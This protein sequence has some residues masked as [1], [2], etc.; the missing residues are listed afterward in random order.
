MKHQKP[1]PPATVDANVQKPNLHMWTTYNINTEVTVHTMNFLQV[2]LDVYCLLGHHTTA[3]PLVV[4]GFCSPHICPVGL[5]GALTSAYVAPAIT[6][7]VM[8]R[9]DVGTDP[10]PVHLLLVGY[11]PLWCSNA[12]S[13]A[14][15][16]CSIAVF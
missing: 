4:V 3:V 7:G 12:L 15:F 9:L 2:P 1:N 5:V 11:S 13:I 10:L 8:V 6:V 16:W 14:V